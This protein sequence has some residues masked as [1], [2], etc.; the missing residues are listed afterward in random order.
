MHHRDELLPDHCTLNYMSQNQ[1]EFEQV[2]RHR[3]DSSPYMSLYSVFIAM[4]TSVGRLPVVFEQLEGEV[5]S[6]VTEMVLERW[7]G[8]YSSWLLSQGGGLGVRISLSDV[9]IGSPL[10][11]RELGE[12]MDISWQFKLDF[13]FTDSTWA[14]ETSAHSTCTGTLIAHPTPHPTLLSPNNG[15]D[16]R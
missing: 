6:V 14:N 15:Y 9:D 7:S 8:E 13:R 10:L 16:N 12:R 1:T 2:T 3:W 4:R 5:N 11:A